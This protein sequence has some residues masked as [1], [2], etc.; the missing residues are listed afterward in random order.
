MS[1]ERTHKF[2]MIAKRLGVGA[3]NDSIEKCAAGL[4]TMSVQINRMGEFYHA[5]K[6]LEAMDDI[7]FRASI[8][9]SGLNPSDKFFLGMIKDTLILRAYQVLT[10]DE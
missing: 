4:S 8:D 5:D 7:I 6:F 1:I 2:T 10:K 3:C 9:K